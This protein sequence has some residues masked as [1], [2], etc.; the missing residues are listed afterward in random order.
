MNILRYKLNLKT[1]W[2]HDVLRL[3]YA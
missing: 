3:M 1:F 2:T